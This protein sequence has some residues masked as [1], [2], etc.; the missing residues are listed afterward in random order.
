MPVA[1][2]RVIF[3]GS[4]PFA[5]PTLQA[6]IAAGHEIVGVYC[7]APKPA[8]RGQNMTSCAVETFASEKNIPTFVPLKL[9]DKEAEAFAALNADVAVVVAYGMILPKAFLHAPKYG[10]INLHPSLLPRWRGAAP[11]QRAVLAGDTETAATIM[12]MDEGC[13][14]GPIL[15]YKK[16][17]ITTEDTSTTMQDK[18][19]VL[20]AELMVAALAGLQHN[21]LKPKAQGEEGLI[22]ASK[23]EKDEGKL[24]FKRSAIELDCV[25]R[26]MNPWPLAYFDYRSERI[27]VLK[28]TPL[29]TDFKRLK[30]GEVITAKEITGDGSLCIATGDGLLRLDMLQRPNRKV[31]SAEELVKGF[32]IAEGDVIG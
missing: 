12:Q 28:A 17:P 31:M 15:L 8:G 7:Q 32:P 5:I 24:N 20:G 22:Y 3:M 27:K 6:L 4:P 23:L 21:L 30:P 11:V 25:V 1:P 10:C 26:G 13:D 29:T 9:R 16:C 19:S 2:M 14:T 18:L